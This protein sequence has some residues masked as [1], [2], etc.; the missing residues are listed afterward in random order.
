ME[1]FRYPFLDLSQSQRSSTGDMLVQLVKN[2][3]DR[4]ANARLPVKIQSSRFVWLRATLD[5]SSV[6]VT[7]GLLLHYE[8]PFR[9]THSC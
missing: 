4:P 9:R 1:G 8:I 6:L 3:V 7:F 5:R 2:V